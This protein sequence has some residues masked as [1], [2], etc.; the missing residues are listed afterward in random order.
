MSE[1][2]TGVCRLCLLEMPLLKSHYMP[3]ALYPTKRQKA[4]SKFATR[5]VVHTEP[6]P[7]IKNYLLC[8]EC[9]S[10][11]SENGE[12]DVLRW[13]SAKAKTFLLG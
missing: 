5:D 3:A 6:T 12:S 2:P 7:E 8:R 1:R 9:E 4:K 11:F 10:R 13:V